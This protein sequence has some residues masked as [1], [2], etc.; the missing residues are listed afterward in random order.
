M[1]HFIQESTEQE[2]SNSDN[3][4]AWEQYQNYL[5]NKTSPKKASAVQSK[6]SLTLAH[7]ED[8]DNSMFYDDLVEDANDENTDEDDSEDSDDDEIV[9]DVIRPN[10]DKPAKV[11]NKNPIQATEDDDE[12]DYSY[13]DDENDDEGDE[14]KLTDIKQDAKWKEHT[15]I[16]G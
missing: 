3:L 16:E 4:T 10:G 11:V 1:R 8:D 13:E 15:K 7:V 2:L 6:P 14:I 9:D 5:C 12:D